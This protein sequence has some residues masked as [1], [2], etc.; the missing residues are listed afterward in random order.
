MNNACTKW[1]DALL[2]AALAESANDE[3]NRHL[4][5]CAD[6]A[7]EFKALRTRR[8]RMDAL[9]PLVARAAEPS[10]GLRARI[11]AAAEASDARRGPRFW[12]IWA[13]TGAAATVIAVFLVVNL[14][15]KPGLTAAELR[16]ASQLAQ[17]QSPTSDLL[18]TPGQQFMTAM[19]KLGESY[20]EIPIEINQ[21]GR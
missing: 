3:L 10:P 6:C 18:Q 12:R 11:L 20:I 7:A 8:Q 16:K 15:S 19:P 1:K 17:W 4:T 21:G 2:E 9:L 5:Q 14:N 13:V